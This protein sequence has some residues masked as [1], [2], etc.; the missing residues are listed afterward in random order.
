M[1]DA[2]L[3]RKEREKKYKVAKTISPITTLHSK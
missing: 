2:A 1:R 3:E